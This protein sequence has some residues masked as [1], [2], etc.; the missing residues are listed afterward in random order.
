MLKIAIPKEVR[1][2]LAIA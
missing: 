1:Q 2:M